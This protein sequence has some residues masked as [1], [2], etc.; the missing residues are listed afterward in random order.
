MSLHTA[1]VI[2]EK[3]FSCPPAAVH[4]A[5]VEEEIDMEVIE[6]SQ[7]EMM[8]DALAS[9]PGLIIRPVGNFASPHTG[10]MLVCT[11]EDAEMP[12][13]MPVFWTMECS[14]PAIYDGHVHHGFVTWMKQRGWRIEH[15]DGDV[16][17]LFPESC[18]EL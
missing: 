13:G 12:D 10:R 4:F 5:G 8:Q 1:R 2:P 14:D 3:R 9:F 18:L 7:Q 16:F 11:Y 17:L 15:Y 6:I